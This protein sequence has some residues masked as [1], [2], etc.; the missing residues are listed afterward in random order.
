MSAGLHLVRLKVDTRK[1]Y[2]FARRARVGSH[3]FDEGYAVHALLAALFDHDAGD[4]ER[5]AP[6][7][8]HVASNEQ[9]DGASANRPHTRDLQVLGYASHDHQALRERAEMFADPSA[10]D[11]FAIDDMVSKP[12]PSTFPVGM[13]LGFE[14]RVCP[15][16]RIA[17]RGPMTGPGEVDAF[18]ARAWEVGSETTL[19]REDVYKEWLA[20]ELAKG[21][22]KVVDASVQNF[23]IRKVHRL[24]HGATRRAHA[25]KLPDA[26]LVG[27][28]EVGDA[29][30]FVGLLKRGLGRHRAFG[31]G[32][33]LLKPARQT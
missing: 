15:V 27:V 17:Q 16:V 14:V 21:G 30:G 20:N 19:R 22:A 23:S 12:M 18:L 11:L 28:L 32:M 5:F 7:P 29:D 4:T 3:D 6:K 1:L 8:F 9:H 31:F 10:W 24:H 25:A 13:K 33:L 26:T 2:N